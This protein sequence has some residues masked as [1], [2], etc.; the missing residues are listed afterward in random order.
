LLLTAGVGDTHLDTQ[1][2]RLAVE[3]LTKEG[4]SRRPH[5]PPRCS[6]QCAKAIVGV[7]GSTV[8]DD[9]Y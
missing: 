3:K 1:S 5:K 2:V 7:I 4:R 6:F 8:G 9:N